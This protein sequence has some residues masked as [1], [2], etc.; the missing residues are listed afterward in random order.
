M[1]I[2]RGY[3]Y[4]REELTS[5]H[6]QFV[7]TSTGRV[8]VTRV[9]SG[10]PVVLLPTNGHSWHE[11]AAIAD[12]LPQRELVIWDTPG[13]GDSDP[14]PPGMTIDRYADVLVEVLDA[15]GIERAVVTGCSVGAFIAA[16]IATRHA[17]RVSAV[18]LVELQFRELGFWA[19]DEMW[20]LVERMFSVPT[21][22]IEQVQPRFVRPIDDAHLER[23]NI[24]RNKAG[25]R[26][27][28][29]VM[30]AIRAFDLPPV[31]ADISQPVTAVFGD[32]GPTVAS[33]GNAERWL[34]GQAE[35][36]VIEGAGHFIAHDQPQA[37]ARVVE[38]LWAQTAAL[39]DA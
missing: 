23:W 31:L 28:L 18:G 35:V 20:S 3:G 32:S 7:V 2:H 27:L 34:P 37:F 39:A 10:D 16:S 22:S 24:D 12:R 29:E 21:Q 19:T 25:T 17:S 36:V 26:S 14:A 30:W 9:G 13:Q 1:R 11:F 4:N 5:M 38:R 8:R 6:Q 15:L 33:K